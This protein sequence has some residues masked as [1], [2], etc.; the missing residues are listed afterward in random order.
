MPSYAYR[1]PEHGEVE[2]RHP[3][4]ECDAPQHCPLLVRE[5][6]NGFEV[7]VSCRAVMERLIP[8]SQA[9]TPIAWTGRT[10]ET[11]PNQWTNC[12]VTKPT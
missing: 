6:R 11:Q 5:V 1:C 8:A 12:I 4:S 9:R 2:V 3:M 10:R 7:E